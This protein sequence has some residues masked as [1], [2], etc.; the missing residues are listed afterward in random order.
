M[1]TN[2]F[3]FEEL[4]QRYADSW[5][6][7]PGESML[8]VC[9]GREIERGTPTRSFFANDLEPNVQAQMTA[10]NILRWADVYG[11]PRDLR[12]VGIWVANT[13]R[14]AWNCDAI[15]DNFGTTQARFGALVSGFAR[16]VHI[17]TTPNMGNLVM[18]DDSTGGP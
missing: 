4:Y 8:S 18:Y 1:L 7:A 15:D 14:R 3:P 10:G 16:P 6:V 17:T 2:P 5:R 9:G 11:N 13:G 12:Y